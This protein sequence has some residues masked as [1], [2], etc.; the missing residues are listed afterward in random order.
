MNTGLKHTEDSNL[1]MLSAYSPQPSDTRESYLDNQNNNERNLDGES[2]SA[3]Q[4]LAVQ[5][6]ALREQMKNMAS[7]VEAIKISVAQIVPLDKTIAELSIHKDSTQRDLDLLWQRHDQGKERDDKLKT[8]IDNVDTKIE[9]FQ[10][11]FN[12]GMKVF[13]TMFGL[14]Q[15]CIMGSVIWVFTHV[16]DADM[17][18]ML[19]DQRIQQI[20]QQMMKEPRK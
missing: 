16:N 12:G 5:M 13:L 8:D 9:A 7:S 3:E 20:E 18:N 15:A 4:D 19:Q 17:V 2:M 1:G 6:A 11:S 10:N 14:V